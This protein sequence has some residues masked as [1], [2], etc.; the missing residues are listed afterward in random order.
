MDADPDAAVLVLHQ[1]DVVV[2]RAHCAELRFRELC[3]PALR[4]EVRRADLLE[5]GVVRALV[6]GDAH[7]ER[8]ATRDLAHDRVDAAA[9]VEVAARQL[10]LDGLV[11]APMS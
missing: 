11:P 9:L 8:D 3:H 6:R 4:V 10:G 7:A 1:V 5:D 2:A